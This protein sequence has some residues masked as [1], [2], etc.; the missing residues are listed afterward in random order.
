MLPDSLKL[1]G[2]APDASVQQQQGLLPSEAS[3]DWVWQPVAPFL[4]PDP[5]VPAMPEDDEGDRGHDD[6]LRA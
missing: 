1:P 5:Q 3:Q 2:F 6:W 4:A